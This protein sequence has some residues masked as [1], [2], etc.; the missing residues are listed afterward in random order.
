M[1]SVK[2]YVDCP[3]HGTAPPRYSAPYSLP[4]G[5]EYCP[6]CDRALSIRAIML[7]PKDK[8]GVCGPLCWKGKFKC[9]CVCEGLCHGKGECLCKKEKGD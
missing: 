6:Q 4:S 9:N 1:G 7:Q 5:I 3:E 8:R 2:R